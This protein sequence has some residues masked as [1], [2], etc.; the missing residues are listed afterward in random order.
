MYFNKNVGYIKT[1]KHL[2]LSLTFIKKTFRIWE[3]FQNAIHVLVKPL[4]FLNQNNNFVTRLF[5]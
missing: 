5:I 3:N 2:H 1:K 4:V